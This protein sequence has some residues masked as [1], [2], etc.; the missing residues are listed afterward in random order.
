VTENGRF[1]LIIIYNNYIIMTFDPF[2]TAI[3]CYITCLYAF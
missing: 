3:E 2:F 1:Y